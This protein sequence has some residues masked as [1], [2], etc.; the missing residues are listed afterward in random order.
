[1]LELTLEKF[2]IIRGYYRVGLPDIGAFESGASKYILAIQDDIV[3]DKDTTFVTREDTL[4]F[5]ITTNDIDGNLVNSNESVQWSIF[6][7]AKYVTLI[8]SDPN[9]SGGSATATFK[10][11]E[12]A[13]GKG[14]RFRIEAEIGESIMRSEMYVIEELV[15]G[16][17]PPVPSI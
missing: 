16:A 11:S 7:S 9:T 10:V 2:L 17:P 3:G 6:P 14:F 1:M 5:T 12:Q 13:K 8:T 15:T 4:E